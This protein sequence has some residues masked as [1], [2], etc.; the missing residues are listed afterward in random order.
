M[1]AACK[2]YRDSGVIE[3]A[4]VTRGDDTRKY[5]KF[6]TAFVRPDRFRFEYR[7]RGNDGK[8]WSRHIVSA[9]G[10]RVRSWWDAEPGVIDWESLEFAAN[11]LCSRTNVP[12]RT[13]GGLMMPKQVGPSFLADARDLILLGYEKIDGKTCYKI[14]GKEK[15]GWP[16]TIWIEKKSKLIRRVEEKSVGVG[17]PI[18]RTTT[19][20]ARI[21]KD[22]AEKYLKFDPPEETGK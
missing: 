14:C 21:N 11:E 5:M 6:R 10:G 20:K 18:F 15:E 13:V 2:S 3:T 12:M 9:D 16:F 4:P 19:Y 7:L 17:I 8:T 22:V 1:Y